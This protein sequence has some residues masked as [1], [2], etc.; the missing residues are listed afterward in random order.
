M[1]RNA[2][3]TAGTTTCAVTR[4]VSSR[5]EIVPSGSSRI[6]VVEPSGVG[7]R[8]P[9]VI[10]AANVSLWGAPARGVICSASA[11]TNVFLGTSR[12][13]V[14]RS[15]TTAP[16]R[17]AVRSAASGDAARLSSA[18]RGDT[19]TP[20]AYTLMKP[21][22]T[23][24]PQPASLRPPCSAGNSTPVLGSTTG[25]AATAAGAGADGVFD[26]HQSQRLGGATTSA[27]AAAAVATGARWARTRNAW[28]YIIS[29]Q[30]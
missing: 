18:T 24:T 11:S 17:R 8:R 21:Y 16:S 13:M 14:R 20:T 28:R 10:A 22:L 12:A 23:R 6:V 2:S 29:L 27:V 19:Y 9:P 15:S 7:S 4:P 25:G 3:Q 26:D 30:L 5:T 1:S